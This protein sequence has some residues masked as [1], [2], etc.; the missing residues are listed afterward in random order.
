MNTSLAA[1]KNPLATEN[2]GKLIMKFAIPAMISFL[3]NALYNIVDQIFIGQGVGMYGNAATNVA[4]PFNTVCTALALL[5]GIGAASNFNLRLGAGKDDEAA[6]VAGTGLFL[7]AVSGI[8]ITA[9]TYIFLKP[10]LYAFGATENVYPYAYTY[11]SI[12]SAGY[13]LIIFTIGCGQLVRA[14]GSPTYSMLTVLSG[15]IINT[16]LDPIF[17]F[18][19]NMGMA[20]AALATVIGQ[21]FSAFMA[22]RYIFRFKS[23]RLSRQHFRVRSQD[24]KAI[25][26]LGLPSCF[27]QISMAV[28]QITMNN[29]LI[30]YGAM[31]RY[32]ADIPLASV[33]VIS[34]IN[35]LF[36]GLTIGIAQGCQPIIGFNYGA[37]NY[38]RVRETYI[39]GLLA[40]TAISIFFF[41]VFQ[42]FPRQIVSIFGQGSEL[43]F[44]FAER[45]LRI[46]ML[47]TF[48]NGIQPVTAN[49]FTSIGK[50]RVGLFISLTRQ[51]I[52]LLPL[53]LIL[54][55]IF[56][57]DGLMYAG[58]VADASAVILAFIFA[59]RELRLLSAAQADVD[60]RAT[61]QAGQS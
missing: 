24:F 20:G 18:G 13:P 47:L 35:I 44:Q 2:T 7:L 34:K 28:V 45:Y 59:L 38:N 8:A 32:G 41:T 42:I 27:N 60:K 58:P 25:I 15:A 31:S 30:H 61:R 12:V 23:V 10:L 26:S 54:P 36:V 51:I 22:A 57:I 48:I 4:F 52:F 40:A 33:G 3:V 37:K 43:Y 14:D 55:T 5:L 17:I 19:L 56:G 21:A 53:I 1:Q 16:I 49:F 39:K 11:T 50:A 29:A 6:N 9:L 46:F